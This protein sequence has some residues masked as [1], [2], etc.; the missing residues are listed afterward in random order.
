MFIHTRHFRT[1]TRAP[2]AFHRG[3]SLIEV[4]IAVGLFTIS[5]ATLGVMG[6]SGMTMTGGAFD[7]YHATTLVRES[8][9]ALRLIRAENFALLELG[10]YGLAQ[11]GG[12]WTLTPT[13]DTKDK[14]TRTVT[15][16]DT[17]SGRRL[18]QVRVLWQNTLG[19]PG[20]VSADYFVHQLRG[21]QL[22]HTT[23]NDFSGGQHN[24]SII[25][26]DGDGA[27]GLGLF[28]SRNTYAE[29]GLADTGAGEG[30][31]T[32]LAE[33][34]GALFVATNN[35]LGNTITTIDLS[36]AGSGVLPIRHQ[37]EL[38]ARTFA[39][40]VSGDYLF[41]ATEDD[42]AEVHILKRS[43][44]SLVNTLDLPGTADA[45]ALSANTS[46]LYVGRTQSASAP[47]VYALDITQ[48]EVSLPIRTTREFTGSANALALIDERL[49]VG[50]SANNSEV[51]LLSALD[52]SQQGILALPGNA[53][54]TTMTLS[55]TILFVGRTSSAA[56][57]V[58][59][60]DIGDPTLPLAT[61]GGADLPSA[62]RG[63]A[64]GSE[65]RLAVA[66]ALP[67]SEITAYDL[68]SLT[69]AQVFDVTQ[70]AGARAVVA[71]GP[72]LYVGLE[73]AQN[74][75]V[76]LRGGSAS[77]GTLATTQ[78]YD[79]T[80]TTDALSIAR[81]ADI[82][83]IGSGVSGNPELTLLDTASTPPAIHGTLEV[84][85]DINGMTRS[86]YT[87]FLATSDNN[88]ELML[89][90][91]ADTAAPAI[92]SAYNLPTNAD[93]RAI[94][95]AG[96]LLAVGTQNASGPTGKEIHLFD[97]SNPSTPI[98]RAQAEMSADVNGLAFLPEGFLVA[99]TGNNAKELI[100][101]DT[102]TQGVLSEYASYNTTGTADALAVS[103]LG[104]ER[105]VLLTEDNGTASD[106]YFFT[107]NTVSSGVVLTSFLDLGADE[108]AATF[109]NDRLFVA[110][111]KNGGSVVTIDPTNP[112][113]P[114]V[115]G[116]HAL[117]A[118]PRAII[119]D[120]TTLA[121]ATAGND[122][123]FVAIAPTPLATEY[124]RK[125]WFTSPAITAG[126]PDVVWG[127]LAWTATGASTSALQIRTAES[128][129]GLT[130]ALWV[131]ENGIPGAW[132]TEPGGVVTPH[133]SAAGHTW[134]SYRVQLTGDGATTPLV[135][136]VS[137]DYQ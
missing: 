27:I 16:T 128:A 121:I 93:A 135:T 87:L 131:G 98:L 119:T 14:Y 82:T 8:A 44:L 116:T 68:P 89:V 107:I 47:E 133:Q 52:L 103:V 6:V 127:A 72:F 78:T 53:D 69:G 20:E 62:V 46:T 86:G 99:A 51:T 43:D 4:L 41:C 114:I 10:T 29:A 130:D 65:G 39:F 35:A 3:V 57:E 77:W 9:T 100:V 84:G 83:I 13:P 12:K 26:P 74:E 112:S 1:R 40:S 54:I 2:H 7:R 19:I 105:V 102:R 136:D 33:Y 22:T 134:I 32:A 111:N 117:G 124:N 126:S 11:S 70:G 42:V 37:I 113:A 88:R 108:R 67:E 115:L 60:I 36:N 120:M 50:T 64:V 125:G 45:L 58:V 92:I 104:N 61:S 118:L 79:T 94:A 56:E 23:E 106:L 30:T 80:G 5:V 18:A 73:N 110:N 28:G 34:D 55:G 85:A 91:I 101:L 97:I 31:V 49:F 90:N 132:F 63:S 122:R 75:I 129:E 96:S 15:I 71:V 25:L 109:A 137:I 48:P 17:G 24:G 21:T 123:E 59:R 95:V 76:Q 81:I 66:T 38:P